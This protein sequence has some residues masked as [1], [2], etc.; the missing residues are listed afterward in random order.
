[1]TYNP[2]L[3]SR[4]TDTTEWNYLPRWVRTYTKFI[5]LPAWLL[6]IGVQLTIGLL[7]HIVIA[8]VLGALFASGC[9]IQG[10]YRTRGLFR[11]EL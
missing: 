3:W 6:M 5:T 4:L 9:L 11:G 2:T 1:M 8:V 10:F 7:E